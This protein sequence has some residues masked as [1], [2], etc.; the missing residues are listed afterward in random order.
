MV[1]HGHGTSIRR[2]TATSDVYSIV[3]CR[4]FL[5]RMTR[6]SAARGR[7]TA[8]RPYVWFSKQSRRL[9]HPLDQPS[10]LHA[11]AD[12]QTAWR[13]DSLH[14]TVGPRDDRDSALCAT[15]HVV[16]DR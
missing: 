2:Q 5:S 9:V 11:R 8:V 14:R 3:H 15:D 13:V 1:A 4:P 7:G 12:G 16:D 10:G 6:A